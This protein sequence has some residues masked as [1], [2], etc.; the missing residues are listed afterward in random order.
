MRYI[1]FVVMYHTMYTP[2]HYAHSYF[3]TLI[4][5]HAAT[6]ADFVSLKLDIDTPSLEVS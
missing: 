1:V 3:F 4:I 2:K 6:P 5:L